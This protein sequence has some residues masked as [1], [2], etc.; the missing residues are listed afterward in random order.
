MNVGNKTETDSQN[1]LVATCGEREAQRGPTV[2]GD[3][4]GGIFMGLYEV[5]CVKLLKI[6]KHYRIF[7]SLIQ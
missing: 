1:K 5:L 2:M 4:K 3:K 7:K 6:L